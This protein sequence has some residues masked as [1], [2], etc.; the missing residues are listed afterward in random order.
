MIRSILKRCLICASSLF[1]LALFSQ[2]TYFLGGGRGER[3]DA[4][5][6][7]LT[8]FNINVVH[9]DI[10]FSLIICVGPLSTGPK[11]I[12]LQ[13]LCPSNVFLLTIS[14]E[15]WQVSDS[16][17]CATVLD[18]LLCSVCSLVSVVQCSATHCSSAVVQ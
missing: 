16:G 9:L 18:C 2:C 17:S 14:G 7:T 6:N 11:N 8:L 10:S 15:W 4:V 1:T 13:I 12:M 5:F 3:G